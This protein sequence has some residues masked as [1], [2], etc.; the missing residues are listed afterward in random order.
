MT[1]T[2][3]LFVGM[4]DN[5]GGVESYCLNVLRN[6]DHEKFM[7]DFV[8]VGKHELAHAQQIR[9]HGSKIIDIHTKKDGLVRYVRELIVLFKHGDY[10]VIEFHFMGFRWFE[11]ILFARMFS[12]SKIIIHAHTTKV[13]GISLTHRVIDL[14]GR[15]MVGKRDIHRVACTE[16]AGKIFFRGLPFSVFHNAINLNEYSY[17]EATRDSM[18]HTLGVEDK[19]VI[20]HIGTFSYAKNQAFLVEIMREL[21]NRGVNPELILVGEGLLKK[22]IC[23]MAMENKLDANIKVLDGTSDVA[24]L[25][26]AFDLFVLPSRY[27]GLGMV[28][29]EAQASGLRCLASNTVPAEAKIT[30]EFIFLPIDYGVQSWADEIENTMAR[31]YLRTANEKLLATAGYDIRQEINALEK[32]YTKLAGAR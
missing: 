19:F 9:E 30:K 11:P 8:N 10:D 6:I 4:T 32:Y 17:S 21:K 25:M 2:K 12:S 24:S 22:D 16:T 13:T 15:A 29:I 14:I 1:R 28:L 23:A 26:Q 18:R 20:G 5:M 31:G 7:I 27:E 3:I